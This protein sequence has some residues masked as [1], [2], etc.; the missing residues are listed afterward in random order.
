MKKSIAAAAAMLALAACGQDAA[1]QAEATATAAADDAATQ[2]SGEEPGFEAV[3]PGNYQVEQANGDIDQMT[4]HPGMTWSRVAADGS[5]TG[6]TIFMQDG[7]T[8]FVTEGVDGHTCFTDGPVQEDGSMQA[9]GEDGTVAT[10]RPAPE[11][12]AAI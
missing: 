7:K 12:Q 9:T 8:C 6:G 3:A 2:L 5:A 10:V 4:I 1:P 11:D